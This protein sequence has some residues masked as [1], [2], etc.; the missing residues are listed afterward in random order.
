MRQNSG[1]VHCLYTNNHWDFCSN[2]RKI[3]K[4][5]REGVS[6]EERELLLKMFKLISNKLVPGVE[7]KEWKDCIKTKKSFIRACE[8]YAKAEDSFVLAWSYDSKKRKE[9]QSKSEKA[10]H[11]AGRAS[12]GAWQSYC[13]AWQVYLNKYADDLQ[14]LHDEMFPDCHKETEKLFS[15]RNRTAKDKDAQSQGNF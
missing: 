14:K 1:L 5:I 4:Y 6:K 2:Y 7:S 12:Y 9:I 10:C 13:K 11:K 3:V 8:A 15:Q